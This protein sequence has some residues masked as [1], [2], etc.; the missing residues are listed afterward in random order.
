MEATSRPKVP[1]KEN[2]IIGKF[3]LEGIAGDLQ[4]D[5]PLKAGSPGLYHFTQSFIQSGSESLQGQCLLNLSGQL[6]PILDSPHSEKVLPYVP[7][8]HSLFQLML[9]VSYPHILILLPLCQ[10][11]LLE[12]VINSWK[13]REYQLGADILHVFMCIKYKD[14]L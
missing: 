13:V 9:V 14:F 5:I 6:A 4:S 7:S 10:A 3:S 8:E 11:W 1:Q 12:T 2:G